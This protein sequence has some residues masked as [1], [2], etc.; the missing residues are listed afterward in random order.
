MSVELHAELLHTFYIA[1][2]ALMVAL[3]TYNVYGLVKVAYRL[4]KFIQK[5]KCVACSF[6]INQIYLKI[7]NM[8]FSQFKYFIPISRLLF[9]NLCHKLKKR[10]FPR[11]FFLITEDATLLDNDPFVLI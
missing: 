9:F 7:I 1:M 4:Q 8:H 10:F 2:S 6:N 3:E 5:F 11:K